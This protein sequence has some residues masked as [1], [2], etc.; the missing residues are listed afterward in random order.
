MATVRAALARE[1]FHHIHPAAPTAATVT[2]TATARARRRDGRDAGVARWR[3]AARSVAGSR[4]DGYRSAGS[5]AIARATIRTRL[6]GVSVRRRFTSGASE[7]MIAFI[8][9]HAVSP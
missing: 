2:S 6:G 1:D 3:M 4:A 7:F 5:R 9:A 8:V